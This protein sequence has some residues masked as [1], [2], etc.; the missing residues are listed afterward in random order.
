[1]IS[2]FG[3][4]YHTVAYW[5]YARKSIFCLVALAQVL[6]AAMSKSRNNN[7]PDCYCCHVSI[8]VWWCGLASFPSPS[9]AVLPS[10]QWHMLS[11]E[12]SNLLW[13]A[14][15]R[16]DNA[17][18]RLLGY[19][20]HMFP[21]FPA[22]PLLPCSQNHCPWKLRRIAAGHWPSSAWKPGF[23]TLMNIATRLRKLA[24]SCKATTMTP[25]ISGF[26]PGTRSFSPQQPLRLHTAMLHGVW[27]MH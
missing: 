20:K 2:P 8:L 25:C 7:Y 21:M 12:S 24:C 5:L 4:K 9:C 3:T 16:E 23:R 15:M 10:P 17:Y 26:S 19:V 11:E 1:M 14:R 18:S 13:F 6:I 27:L 22:P